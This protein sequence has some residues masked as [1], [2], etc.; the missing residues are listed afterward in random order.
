MKELWE[1]GLVA[2][3][4]LFVIVDPV[5]AV[6]A[7]LAMTQGEEASLRARTARTASTTAFLVLTFFALTGRRLFHLLGLSPEALSIAGG[8]ILFGVSLSMLK[9]QPSRLMRT[10]E[11]IEEGTR[12][13]EV[14]VIPLGVPMLGG[15]GAI[16]AVVVLMGRVSSPVHLAVLL[17]AIAAVSLATYFILRGGTFVERALG[18]TG[19]KVVTR[20]MGLLLAALSVQFV[21]NG[22]SKYMTGIKGI[23]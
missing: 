20:L 1:F 12:K 13:E 3:S 8:V 7:F 23:G 15:P 5:G 18:D 21:L 6:P 11:E 9:V 22:V 16:T 19:M 10:P 4:T 17:T 14:G 2:F